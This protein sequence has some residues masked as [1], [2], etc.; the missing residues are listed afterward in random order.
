MD[1]SSGSMSPVRLRTHAAR[2]RDDP[3]VG[4][5]HFGDPRMVAMYG[6]SRKSIVEVELTE[7]EDGPYYGWLADGGVRMI[8]PNAVLF[9]MQFP[10]GSSAEEASG[11]GRVVRLS[12]E[13]VE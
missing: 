12:L 2:F 5:G 9:E 8:Q 6:H 4:F 1:T 13:V 11:N 3:E 10:Y 7:S